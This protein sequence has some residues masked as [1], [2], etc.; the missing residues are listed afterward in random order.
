MIYHNQGHS[1]GYNF[2]AINHLIKVE[3]LEEGEAS[4]QQFRWQLCNGS[5]TIYG[6]WR[7]HG[8]AEPSLMQ[9]NEDGLFGGG[10]EDM[11]AYLN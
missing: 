5:S 10:A 9:K 4:R 7:V 2:M 8:G 3:H 6:R 11:V 1:D